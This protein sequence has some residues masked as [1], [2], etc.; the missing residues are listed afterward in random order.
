MPKQT[1]KYKAAVAQGRIQGLNHTFDDSAKL[2]DALE[3]AGWFWDSEAGTWGQY[4]K[5]TSM[6]QD[7]EGLSTGVFRLRLM[8]DPGD[9]DR[10]LELIQEAL[11][12]YAVVTTEVSPLYHN[13][14][15]PGVR[16]Y[17]TCSLPKEVKRGRKNKVK[18]A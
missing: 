11:D 3:R 2:Y 12:T 10:L 6:F 7:D 5:S 9:M 16:H 1:A 14:R 15:G 8:A 17:L 13:R 4:Q 18:E